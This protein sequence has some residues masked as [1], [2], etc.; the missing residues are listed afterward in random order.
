MSAQKLRRCRII[1][2]VARRE[3]AAEPAMIGRNTIPS[4]GPA[5]DTMPQPRRRAEALPRGGDLA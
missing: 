3:A 1:K 4:P 5:D 2:N